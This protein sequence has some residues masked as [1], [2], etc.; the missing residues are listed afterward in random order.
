AA[1]RLRLELEP[2]MS[3]LAAPARLL[4]ELAFLLD[5]LLERFAIRDLRLADRGLDAELALH[6]ID[7]DLEVQF[8]H[9]GNDRLPRFLVA[10]HTER[11]IF[12]RE[13]AERDAHLLL[14]ALGLRLDGLRDDRLGKLH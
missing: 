1:G 6:A 4:D 13:P 2:D 11:R 8:S 7:D 9:P 14:V 3:V 5:R 10:A 12:L